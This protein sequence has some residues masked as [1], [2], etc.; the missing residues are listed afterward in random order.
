MQKQ[1]P[2]YTNI[3]RVGAYSKH[4]QSFSNV[5]VVETK[6]GFV[7]SDNI[8]W[9]V[10]LDNLFLC[11][12]SIYGLFHSVFSEWLDGKSAKFLFGSSDVN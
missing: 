9:V 5:G 11:D 10:Y 3:C 7:L 1:P 6:C 8:V 12:S 2:K 4:R